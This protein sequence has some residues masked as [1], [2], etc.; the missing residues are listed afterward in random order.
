MAN[1]SFI[2]IKGK[3]LRSQARELIANVMQFMQEEAEQGLK[4]PLKNFKERILAATKISESSYRR[5]QKEAKDI[6][7]GKSLTFS[8]PRKKRPR[9]SPKK[10]MLE[11]EIE[12]IR[13]I[14]HNYSILEKKQP[15]LKGT[16]KK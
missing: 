10:N 11:G 7:S 3:V 13:S 8:S 4:I 1:K 12:T 15:T 14:I 16:A 5:I 9:S 6:E 2:G